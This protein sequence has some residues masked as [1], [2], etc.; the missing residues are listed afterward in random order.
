MAFVRILISLF[1]IV[2]ICA[3]CGPK[4]EKL[5]PISGKIT[6]Q[7]EP[8]PYGTIT[9]V[10]DVAAGNKT[11]LQPFGKVKADGSYSVETDGKP[12][13]PVGPYL[14]GISSIKPSTPEDGYKPPVWAASQEYLDPN[15]SG[16]KLTVVES[17]AAG[18]Y[19]IV[20][21]KK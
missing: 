5:V 11:K 7:G 18:A 9:L 12:G 20:L 3:G 1:A 16:L 2:F 10:P 17:P 8:L 21:T 19:D 4:P 14:V 15:K 6:I 13:A